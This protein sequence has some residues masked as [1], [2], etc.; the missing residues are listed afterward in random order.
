MAE[1]L[2]GGGNGDGAQLVQA[3]DREPEL[4][5]P[6]EHEHDAVAA[7]DAEG[8]KVVCRLRGGVLDILEGEAPLGHVVCDM[9]HG[10][11]LGRLAGDL[12]DNVKG[13][14]EAV[15]VLE[16]QILEHAVCVLLGLDEFLAQQRLPL[17][18]DGGLG[19][20]LLRLHEAGL[21]DGL[22]RRHDHG[23]EGAVLAVDGDHAVGRG[24]V[25]VD[26]VALVQ[27]L[28]M[29]ADA[30]TQG[31]GDDEVEFLAGVGG[32]VDGLI[33]QL[34]GVLVGDPVGRRHLLAE[35][36]RHVLDD[37]AVLHGGHEALVPAVHRVGGQ[38]CAAALQELNGLDAHGHGGLVQEGEGQ[39]H[40]AGLVLDVLRLG[41]AGA[42]RHLLGGKA[43]DV[44]QLPDTKRDLQKLI[45]CGLYVHRYFSCS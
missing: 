10:K 1:K 35:Q 7:P 34:C 37:D 12:V 33:L 21:L 6:L 19:L 31:A 41:D 3:E 4:V 2:V 5:V 24:A 28:L 25:V 45:V 22:V 8:G 36:R 38:P 11:L 40:P 17:G 44:A 32:G 42:G 29:L 26:A 30:H 20:F 14:V 13:K 16:A 43:H 9:K 23:E 18:L 15:L 39:V 27:D